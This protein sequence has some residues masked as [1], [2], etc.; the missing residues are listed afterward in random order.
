M[1]YMDR[2]PDYDIKEMGKKYWTCNTLGHIHPVLGSK[3]IFDD[4][5][6]S[7]SAGSCPVDLYTMLTYDKVS[8]TA[9]ANLYWSCYLEE[10]WSMGHLNP[11]DALT[12][13][14]CEA[15]QMN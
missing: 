4:N 1:Y 13:R 6:L 15:L 3:V 7:D 8:E 14:R 11:S 9:T 10:C 12:F 5:T 2:L